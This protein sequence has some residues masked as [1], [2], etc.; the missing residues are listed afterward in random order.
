[1]TEQNHVVPEAN[2]SSEG[3]SM[4][5]SDSFLLTRRSLLK[6]GIGTAGLLVTSG[7]GFAARCPS[8]TTPRQTR[9]PY[10]PYDHVVS[11]PIRESQNEDISLIEANDHN[12]TS[13]KGKEGIAN[14]QI[15]YFQGQVLQSSSQDQKQSTV[16]QPLAGALVFLW[17]ANFSGRYNH[18]RDETAHARFRHPKTGNTIERVHDESFQY[19]G[20]AITDAQGRFQFKTILPGFYPAADGWYRPPHL[21]FSIRAQGYPEFVTQT[22][23]TGQ[24]LPDIDMIHQLNDKDHILH[25]S[26]INTK[27]REQ[28]VVEYRQDHTGVL[29]DGL[30]GTCQFL[31]PS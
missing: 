8:V 30:V 5:P 15:I 17:Q 19:W 27:Q 9:G 21:H 20:K 11:Y 1:M 13:I 6:V 12:L 14:G 2:H 4:V 26:R 31:L 29:T 23:F 25:D 22:Y 10:F 16:C 7:V 24:G 28:I 18:Q 3:A